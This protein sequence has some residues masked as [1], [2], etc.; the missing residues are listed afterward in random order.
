MIED[1]IEAL[2]TKLTELDEAMV[3]ASTDF[4]KLGELSAQKED[5]E[6]QLLEKMER[7]EYL[8]ELND[9]IQAQKNS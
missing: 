9:Q 8:S 6:E 1:E 5:V 7:F 4:V 2:E 3:L